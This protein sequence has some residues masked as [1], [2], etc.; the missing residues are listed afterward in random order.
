[1]RD[2]VAEGAAS[3]RASEPFRGLWLSLSGSNE[4]VGLTRGWH[5]GYIC[6]FEITAMVMGENKSEGQESKWEIT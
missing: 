2:E 6:T 3:C 5:S 4:P 1:M